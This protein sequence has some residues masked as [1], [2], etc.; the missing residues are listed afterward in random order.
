MPKVFDAGDRLTVDD[1]E[2]GETLTIQVNESGWL[3]AWITAEEARELWIA[4]GAWLG[5]EGFDDA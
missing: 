3:G 5:E 1:D 4:L 2:S